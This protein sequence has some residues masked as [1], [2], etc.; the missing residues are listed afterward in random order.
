MEPEIGQTTSRPSD[1]SDEDATLDIVR[2][3]V[4]TENRRQHAQSEATGGAGIVRAADSKPL[5]G[6][7][8]DV[9]GH[10]ANGEIRPRRSFLKPTRDAI[11]AHSGPQLGQGLTHVEPQVDEL[12]ELEDLRPRKLGVGMPRLRRPRVKLPRF[13]MPLWGKR[14]S[15]PPREKPLEKPVKQLLQKP[16]PIGGTGSSSREDQTGWSQ[17]A[18]LAVLVA[19]GLVVVFKPWLIPLILF[20]MVWLALILFLV[21]G[22]ARMSDISSGFCNYLRNKYPERAARLLVRLQNAADRLDGILAR[23]PERLVDGIYSPD[24]GRSARDLDDTSIH[25]LDDDPFDRLQAHRTPAE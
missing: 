3:L 6:S 25:A 24:L 2:L 16:E 4:E 10:T 11:P 1:T 7:A 14:A 15:K 19:V 9:V 20:V 18:K 8:G 22:S 17:Y 13:A 21:L 23:M 5:A 12:P